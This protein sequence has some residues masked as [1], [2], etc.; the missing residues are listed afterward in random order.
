MMHEL[1]GFPVKFEWVSSA[2][3]VTCNA[4]PKKEGHHHLNLICND[5]WDTTE[6][7]GQFNTNSPACACC[8]QTENRLCEAPEVVLAQMSSALSGN[9]LVAYS[10]T[11]RCFTG[12]YRTAK[13]V[14][15]LHLQSLDPV[16]SDKVQK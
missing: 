2:C 14:T 15:K 3:S 12:C 9:D 7:N 6:H 16:A 4:F 10:T 8:C 11:S 1:V 13:T 5:D